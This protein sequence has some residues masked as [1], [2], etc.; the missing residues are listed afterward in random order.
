MSIFSSIGSAL[1]KG[2]QAVKSAV[3]SYFNPSSQ[4]LST[5]SSQYSA[6]ALSGLTSALSAGKS[7]SSSGSSGSTKTTTGTSGY[8]SPWQSLATSGISGIPSGA[9]P[10][11]TIGTAVYG[12]Q[13][14]VKIGAGE[15]KV[16][17]STG[18]TSGALDFHYSPEP[19]TLSARTLGAS[20]G[21]ST[22]S[23]SSPGTQPI[24]LNTSPSNVS[25]GQT[26]STRL[27]G[28][29]LDIENIMLLLDNGK[30]LRHQLKKKNL[31]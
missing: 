14:P 9:T 26:D 1:S 15:Q 24:Q 18:L 2:Y 5:P 10:A 19:V 22:G 12:P 17:S 8:I 11:P 21:G 6:N 25:V 28:G 20:D 27:A 13:L 16:S 30:M 31:L 3:S 4:K 23:L 7:T 29:F